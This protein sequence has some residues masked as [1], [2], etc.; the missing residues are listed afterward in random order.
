MGKGIDS[1]AQV[2]AMKLF[3]AALAACT[4]ILLLGTAVIKNPITCIHILRRCGVNWQASNSK[5]PVDTNAAPVTS[6]TQQL[7]PPAALPIPTPAPPTVAVQ[8]PIST[9][10][11]TLEVAPPEPPMAQKP[12]TA[13]IAAAPYHFCW[14]V[15]LPGTTFKELGEL[16]NQDP[17]EVRMDNEQVVKHSTISDH[18][19]IQEYARVKL[20]Y[21]A[22]VSCPSGPHS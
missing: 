1:E 19:F 17:H 16:T 22:G 13:E 15:A 14:R 21:P 18:V 2:E 9:E 5:P 6:C 20:R 12:V 8:V 11:Q 4:A 3:A 7:P 10:A